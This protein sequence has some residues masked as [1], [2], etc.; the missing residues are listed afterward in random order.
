MLY[1]PHEHVK[2]H[3]GTY[4][5]DAQFVGDIRCDLHPRW[6]PDGQAVTFDSVHGGTRQIYVVDVSEITGR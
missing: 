5:A 2:V 6:S 4:H 3:L 1:S